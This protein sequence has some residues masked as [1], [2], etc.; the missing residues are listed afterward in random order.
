MRAVRRNNFNTTNS[1]DGHIGGKHHEGTKRP[2]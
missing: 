1:V 2:S